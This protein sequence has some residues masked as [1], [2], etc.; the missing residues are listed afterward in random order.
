MRNLLVL[1]L[2]FSTSAANAVNSGCWTNKELI[3]PKPK[4]TE[5]ELYP[6]YIAKLIAVNASYDKLT[7]EY[8]NS[9]HFRCNVIGIANVVRNSGGRTYLFK[10]TPEYQ[11][12]KGWE[13]Y[14]F[15]DTNGDCEVLFKFTEDK[16]A[17]TSKGNCNSFCG[18]G[19]SIS[20][21]LTRTCK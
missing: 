17:V 14:G 19:G 10:N 15:Q 12:Y 7:F 8:V 1:L 16:V 4:N 20:A 9:G 18:A 6:P 11:I 3:Q 2:I 21:V 5:K 13:N